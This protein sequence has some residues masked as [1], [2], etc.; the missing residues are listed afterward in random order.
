MAKR[1]NATPIEALFK[2][3]STLPWWIGA[4]LSLVSYVV[5][6]SYAVSEVPVSTNPAQIGQML[7]G[8]L[9]RTLA[10]YGQYLVPAVLIAGAIASYFGRRKRENLID[11]AANDKS[12][13]ALLNLSWQEFELLVGQAFRM[14]GYSVK[15]TGGGGAD[16]GIDLELRKSGEIFLV[17]CKQWRAFKVSVNVVRELF[18]VMAAQGATGG[19]VVTAGVFTADA[20]E[21]SKGR[22]IALI[23]GT[24][25]EKMITAARA[26][27]P[28]A[29]PATDREKPTLT[30]EA[31]IAATPVCPRCGSVMVKRRAKQ[32]SNAGSDFWGCSKYP[33][34]R[35]IKAIE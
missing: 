16:G 21:F 23:D 28:V 31:D 25:L 7:T 22:N 5:I 2:M 18:G 29:T 6:H 32:G 10:F 3:A 35:G 15:E 20:Q 27:T 34:C 4:I 14:Q 12:G 13:N 1:K 8:N 24:A 26:T 17:Q 9:I 11:N 19:F 30:S 33:A